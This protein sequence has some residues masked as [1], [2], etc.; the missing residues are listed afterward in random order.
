[1]IETAVADLSDVLAKGLFPRNPNQVDGAYL[2][3]CKNKRPT[4]DGLLSHATLTNPT[5]L[6]VSTWPFPQLFRLSK[7]TLALSATEAYTLNESTWAKTQLTTYNAASTGITKTITEGGAWQVADFDDVWFASNGVSMLARLPDSG[8]WKVVTQTDVPVQALCGAFGR[9][10]L[11]GMTGS[12]FADARFTALFDHWMRVAA[13]PYQT[14]EGMTFGSNAV[15]YSRPY[16]GEVYY[17]YIDTMAV[18]GFPNTTRFDK[19]KEEL[20]HAVETGQLGFIIPFHSGPTLRIERLGNRLLLASATGITSVEVGERGFAPVDL[21]PIGIASRGAMAGSAAMKYFVDGDGDLWS[22]D[23][24]LQYMRLRYREYISTLTLA[25]VVLVWH[26]DE[27][28]L[29]ITDG[30]DGFVL[31]ENGLSQV[32]NLPTSIIQAGDDNVAL[33]VDLA[34]DETLLTTGILSFGSRLVKT[35]QAVEVEHD[36]TADVTVTVSARMNNTAG[37]VDATAVVAD[38]RGIVT[39]PASGVDMKVSVSIPNTTVNVSGLRVK[40]RADGMLS[41]QEVIDNA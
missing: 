7:Y 16:G 40:T 9:L 18:L 3:V 26:E 10:F 20:Y 39:L 19:M 29:Y 13:E 23:A 21:F 41:M 36:T 28:E 38:S 8:A 11:S 30:T 6:S 35:M 37:F 33:F 25:D 31:S 27:A 14:A 24:N 5:D 2:S 22:I 1:M 4:K 32:T 12:R 17:P 34:D 15:L